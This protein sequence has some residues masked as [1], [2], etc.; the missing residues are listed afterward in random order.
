MHCVLHGEFKGRTC[1]R[2][3]RVGMSLGKRSRGQGYEKGDCAK[4]TDQRTE[5]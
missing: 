3:I 2:W 1:R 4:T 5:T